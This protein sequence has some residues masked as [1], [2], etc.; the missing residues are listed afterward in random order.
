MARLVAMYITTNQ[1]IG[2]DVLVLLI[3]LF[4]QVHGEKLI[5]LA[6]EFLF[7]THLFHH[8]KDIVRHMEREVPRIS[9]DKSFAMGL[10]YIKFLLETA[11]LIPGTGKTFEIKAPGVSDKKRYVK[12]VRLNGKLY[13]KMYITHKDITEGGVL[14]FV[15]SASPNKKRGQAQED[16]PYSLTE[17]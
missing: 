9:F 12:S 3:I 15:M 8:T 14:E 17:K 2:S 1:T 10:K 16:K 4:R 7:T 11:I 13:T 6:E 5:K